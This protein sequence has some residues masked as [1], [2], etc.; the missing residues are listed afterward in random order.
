MLDLEQL[1]ALLEKNR[2]AAK[3]R[4]KEFTI[5][6]KQFAF[7]TRPYFMGVINLS[8]DSWYRESV[9]LSA[10]AAIQRGKLLAAQGADIIDIGAES[11][12]AQAARA[13]DGLQKSKLLPVIE[14]LRDQIL[15]VETYSSDVA[16]QCLSAGAKI[17]NLTGNDPKLYSIA[18]AH[19]AAVI[20]CYVQGPNV[21]EVGDFSLKGDVVAMMHEYFARQLAVFHLRELELP[22]GSQLG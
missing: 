5:G 9:C 12:L 2:E 6:D 21:R 7:N 16:E 11:T 17:L 10:E 20:I 22:L 14:G 13:A 8:P 1:A 18:A 15:S 4:V 3:A 19:D